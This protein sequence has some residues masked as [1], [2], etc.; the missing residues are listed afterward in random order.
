M[1]FIMSYGEYYEKYP[2]ITAI[3]QSYDALNYNI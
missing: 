1:L 3:T 2:A